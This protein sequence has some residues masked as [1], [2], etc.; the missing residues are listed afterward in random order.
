MKEVSKEGVNWDKL[1]QCLDLTPKAKPHKGIASKLFV[2]TW[3]RS[4]C[5][6]VYHMPSSDKM[7]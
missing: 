4:V 3:I 5:Q 2:S 6:N 7:A 1:L